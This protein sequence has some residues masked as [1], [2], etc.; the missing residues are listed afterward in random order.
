MPAAVLLDLASIVLVLR[1]PHK[2]DRIAHD[3]H[4]D[5]LVDFTWEL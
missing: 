2:F 1:L 3:F 5:K 4:L